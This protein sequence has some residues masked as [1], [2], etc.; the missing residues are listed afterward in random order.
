MAS[1][2]SARVAPARA[3]ASSVGGDATVASLGHG[4]GE[5]DE[6][7][8]L[9]IERPRCDGGAVQ[10]LEAP[11]DPGYRLAQLVVQR[12]Q[13]VEDRFSVLVLSHARNIPPPV[14]SDEGRSAS[15]RGSDGARHFVIQRSTAPTRS[16]GFPCRTNRC[17]RLPGGSPRVSSGV[18]PP[19]ATRSRGP[20]L[21]RGAA[22]ACGTGSVRGPAPSSMA[23]AARRRAT[24]STAGPPT[25]RCSRSRDSA[26]PVLDRVAPDHP[27][28]CGPGERGGAGVL[29]PIGRRA[30]RRWHHPLRHPVPLG[31]SPGARR[32]GRLAGTRRARGVRRLRRGRRRTAR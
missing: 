1:A 11:I 15:V 16:R 20:S 21:W 8:R 24:T 4:D 7:F 22:R 13:L 12:L 31:P 27:H 6:L 5:R 9:G 28:R 19:R 2:A 23:R 17:R 10:L 18:S 14:S 3:A 26:V 29:R 25:S 32:P 30:A